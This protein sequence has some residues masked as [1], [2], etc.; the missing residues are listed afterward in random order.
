MDESIIVRA[1][2][3]GSAAL[4]LALSGCATTPVAG[5]SPLATLP[6]TGTVDERFLSYN[7]EMV[8]VTGGRF[9]RP[10]GSAGT[11]MHE[12]R[13][14]MDLS[15][16]RLIAA[17]K[18]LGPAYVRVSGTWANAT[19]FADSDSPPEKAPA[20]FDTILTRQQ[21]RGVVDFTKAVDGQ[22]VT[23]FATSPGTRDSAGVWQTDMAARW[24]AYT[25]SIGGTIAAAEF[26]N[27]PSMLWLT[28]PP[29]GY[30]GADYLRDYERFVQ[31]MRSQSPRTRILAPGT[32]ELGEQ[33][34]E[35]ARRSPRG[36][37][38]EPE[39]LIT[40]DST[41]P[42]GFSFH[43]Y[44]AGSLRCGNVGQSVARALSADW[45]DA[46]DPAI[47]R[48]KALRDA[49]APG[50]PLWN[51]ESAESACGGNPWAAS[52]ADSFRFTD[53]LGRSA[54]QGI[55]VFMH[56]TLAASDYALLEEHGYA[57]RP[58]YWAA[59]LWKR[60]MG[61]T[62]LAAPASPSP[63]VRLYAHCLK[64]GNGGVGIAALNLGD[65]AQPL[66]MASGAQAWVM[67][68]QPIDT[69]A[70][71]VNGKAPQL[72]TDGSISGL[73]AVQTGADFSL[74]ARSITFIA[75]DSAQ[76]PACR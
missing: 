31:L 17:A 44:G 42:N 8:E 26:A 23:S 38:L 5:P 45:L 11:D 33:I 74:P 70:V 63:Q 43:F 71:M 15:D 64:T 55:V 37:T 16:R 28:Q 46:V 7:V 76:N 32:A 29:E 62:V 54:R 49:T 1:I 51:T 57:P 39:E 68:G 50:V 66:S 27:E 24:L 6:V 73:D 61:A 75:A 21:W 60:V 47:V 20:G 18:H 65:S 19:W 59:V 72:A 53:T 13:P 48:I 36:V 2:R 30:T 35:L 69:K 52:F 25:K 4:L 9:W 56:N 3:A 40:A 34:R 22:I 41:R 14:P 67:T 10:F 12:Y 58:N